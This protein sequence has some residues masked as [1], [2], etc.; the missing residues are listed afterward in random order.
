M[1]LASH[2]TADDNADSQVIPVVA[3]HRGL[4]YAE[5]SARQWQWLF[6]LPVAEHPLF[7]NADCSTGQLGKVWFLGGTFASVEIAPGVILGEA[8]RVCT[9]PSG[10]S[11]FFPLISAECSTVEGN[12]ETEEELRGCANFL[13]D[14]IV[15]ESV[16]L[17]IDG[18]SVT[19]V[20]S[21]RVESPLFFLGP[22]PEDNILGDD[23]LAGTISPSV[24]DG[25]WAMVKPLS[26]GLHSLR[27]G[28]L[29][30]LTPIGGPVF[31][32]DIAYEVDVVPRGQYD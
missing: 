9:V 10:T 16:F 30:D 19:N 3:K 17:E 25:Y 6:S 26:V 15:P 11:L 27:F 22:L 12:G 29:V 8:D 2:A 31:I 21:L 5:W 14:F 24:S 18:K 23:E 32:Q 4:S 20:E 1:L 28:G 13:A 7:D